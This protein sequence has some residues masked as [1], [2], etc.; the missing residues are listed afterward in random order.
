MPVSI[1][2]YRALP[3]SGLRRRLRDLLKPLWARPHAER[4]RLAIPGPLGSKDRARAIYAG[5]FTLAGQK[6][7]TRGRPLFSIE[8]PSAAFGLKLHG[9][10]WL[11]DLEASGRMLD[12]VHG[13]ALVTDWLSRERQHPRYARKRACRAER[14]KSWIHAAPFLLDGASLEF[15]TAFR[16]AISREALRLQWPCLRP[17]DRLAS[18]CALVTAAASMAGLES[19]EPANSRR[20]ARALARE[21]PGGFPASRN[22]LDLLRML[23]EL[24]PCAATEPLARALSHLTHADGGLARF[25]GMNHTGRDFAPGPD[26]AQIAGGYARLAA[27]GQSVILDTEGFLG[28]ELSSPAGRILTHCGWPLRARSQWQAAANLAAAHSAPSLFDANPALSPGRAQCGSI[29]EGHWVD[30]SNGVFARGLLLAPDGRSLRGED[31]LVGGRSGDVILRF[32]LEPEA[33]P[34]LSDSQRSVM[35]SLGMEMWDF[36]AS[37]ARLALE[38]SL[39]IAGR[40]TPVPSRQI[41]LSLEAAAPGSTI[42][43]AIRRV[44]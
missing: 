15:D 23:S 9:F 12:R 6:L 20:L 35:V 17:A 37:G 19:L 5:F 38:D 33:M 14:L 30:A 26:G 25:H 28:L 24:P 31:R 39:S 8:P 22:P 36:T 44:A 29:T 7:E 3:F 32:H 2:I 11:A 16:A 42:S 1:A 13:R 43:W 40:E 4:V 27:G 18:A 21:F 10:R 41:T 34:R